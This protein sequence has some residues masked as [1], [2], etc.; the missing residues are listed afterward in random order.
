MLIM[1]Q[2]GLIETLVEHFISVESRSGHMLGR[3][4]YLEFRVNLP[5]GLV[6]LLCT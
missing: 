3:G 5:E 6:L 1:N 4:D 2:E